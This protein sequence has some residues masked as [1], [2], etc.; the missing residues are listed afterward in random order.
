MNQG[1]V[2]VFFS[3]LYV[4]LLLLHLI[5]I[6]NTFRNAF[7]SKCSLE[8]TAEDSLLLA[9]F[10]NYYVG[11][12]LS[13]KYD[14]TNKSSHLHLFSQGFNDVFSSLNLANITAA[15]LANNK[16]LNVH[17]FSLFFKLVY[18]L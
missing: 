1:C 4:I 10:M 16:C 7:F 14:I 12:T 13:A 17:Q 6:F 5:I 8:R 18:I 3:L 15:L 2:F 9:S 11:I